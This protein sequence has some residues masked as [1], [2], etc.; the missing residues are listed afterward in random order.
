MS[1]RHTVTLNDEAF[2][3]L[4]EK[5]TFGETYSQVIARLAKFTETTKDGDT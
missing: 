1:K 2:G 5:G 3:K 4:R